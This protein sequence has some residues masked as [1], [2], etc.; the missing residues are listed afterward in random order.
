MVKSSRLSLQQTISFVT[1]KYKTGGDS[2]SSVVLKKNK[3]TTS[4]LIV[5]LFNIHV[6]N[7]LVP[8]FFYDCNLV[9]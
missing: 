5:V 2:C 8:F 4:F 3:L 9:L 1:V 7:I 6:T